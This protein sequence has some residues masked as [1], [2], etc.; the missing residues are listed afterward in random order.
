MIQ[1]VLLN[2]SSCLLDTTLPQSQNATLGTHDRKHLISSY[3]SLNL[4]INFFK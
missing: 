1:S 4:I 3:F 2:K